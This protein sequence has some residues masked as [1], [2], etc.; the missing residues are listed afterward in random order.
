M[1]IL[2]VVP[3]GKTISWDMLNKYMLK[4]GVPQFSYDSF[5][6][7]YDQTP[8]LQDMVKFDPDGVT[9][10]ADSMDKIPQ[11]APKEKNGV[12]QAAKRA[13]DVGAKL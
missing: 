2:H 1:Q 13:T 5:K 3:K 11:A 6:A 12:S 8:G 4:A 9:V 10:N 7:V